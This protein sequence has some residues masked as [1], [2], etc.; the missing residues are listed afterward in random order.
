MRKQ[1][2][3][4]I[5]ICLALSLGYFAWHRLSPRID[6]EKLF[7]GPGNL[8]IVRSPDKVQVWKTEGFLNRQSDSR[9]EQRAFY[10]KG[11]EP[12]TVPSDLSK[13]LTEKLSNRSSYYS[14]TGSSKA[15]VPM[16]GFV[17][18]FT[19]AEGEVDIFLCFECGILAVQVGEKFKAEADFDPSHNELLRIIKT[20]FPDDENVQSLRERKRR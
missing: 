8:Q 13:S 3:W 20:L 19:R 1:A 16:P 15:C 7:G 12:K 5:A 10:R 2:S 4:F 6:L 11:G 18:A 14:D 9:P 17:I